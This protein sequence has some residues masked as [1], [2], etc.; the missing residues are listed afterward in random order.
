MSSTNSTNSGAWNID[1]FFRFRYFVIEHT[2][3]R[4]LNIEISKKTKNVIKRANSIN[5]LTKFVPM[6]N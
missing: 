6:V 2:H 3:Y 1:D 4:Y 5:Y